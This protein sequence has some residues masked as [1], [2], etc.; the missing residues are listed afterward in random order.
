MNDDL[1]CTFLPRWAKYRSQQNMMNRYSQH[2]QNETNYQYINSTSPRFSVIVEIKVQICFSMEGLSSFIRNMNFSTALKCL[3][4][5]NRFCTN[6]YSSFLSSLYKLHSKTK[7]HSSS[8]LFKLQYLHN[9]CS[10]GVRVC[11]PVSICSLWQ[12]I[13]SLVTA[14]LT[15]IFFILRYFSSLYVVLNNLYDLNLFLA[16]P[17]L[18][19]LY[20]SLRNVWNYMSFN[21][22]P[23]ELTIWKVFVL[24]GIWK[25]HKKANPHSSRDLRT[26]VAQ[27]LTPDFSNS[28][29]QEKAS[30]WK[31]SAGTFRRSLRKCLMA[32]REASTCMG[33]L[34]NSALAARLQDDLGTRND[35]LQN[36]KW[37]DS[38]GQEMELLKE[39]HISEP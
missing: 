2:I 27:H 24:C 31:L 7:W 19:S 26:P 8:I 11:L 36:F 15:F 17:P 28:N 3:K 13:L 16:A 37:I 39:P 25:C 23:I 6:L 21:R 9:L 34:P 32:F 18:L 22:W 5:G 10:R 1:Y 29:W 4:W 14:F 12:L 38:I 20:I 33:Y 30:A 35:C